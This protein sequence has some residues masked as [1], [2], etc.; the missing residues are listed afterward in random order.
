MDIKSLS[1]TRI[2]IIFLVGLGIWLLIP[3]IIGLK[4][5]LAI[6]KQIKI[7]ALILA[8]V[9]ESFFYW[10]LAALNLTLLRM[11][12]EKLNPRDVLKISLLDSFALQFLPISTFGVAAVEYYIY[13]LKNVRTSHIIIIF[14]ARII[15]IWLVFAA[16]YLIGVAFAPANS[17]LDFSKK[18][19]IWSIYFLALAV[20]FYLIYLYL[21]RKLLLKT[22]CLLG[23]LYQ[24]LRQ[25]FHF[26]H[27][28]KIENQKIINLVPKIY[29]AT[30]ILAQNKK[31]QVSAILGALLFWLG[32]IFCLYFVLL[33]L[34][35][36]AHLTIVIFT[37]AASKILA[38]ISFIPGGLGVV[39]ASLALIFIG[40]GI[41]ASIALATVMI[42]RLLSFWL[43]IPVGMG[44][45]LSLQKNYIKMKIREINS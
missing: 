26:F 42:F 15:I 1:W 20:F 31:Y 24:R 27:F 14:I 21:N 2:I 43:P 29:Q 4:E 32:D 9:S 22:F 45:F 13:R 6:L 18:V 19:I 35:G 44:A 33:G 37:Y 41:P 8:I 28:P 30:H 11:V 38:Q 25:I 17:E 3:K 16:I 10:G 12:R 7:W 36:N 40:F 34:G 23:R 39:E 5:T